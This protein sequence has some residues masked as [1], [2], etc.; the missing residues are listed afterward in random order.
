MSTTQ[1][2]RIAKLKKQVERAESKG[3]FNSVFHTL[4]KRETKKEPVES[5]N[6]RNAAKRRVEVEKDG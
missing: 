3:N 5:V 1:N 6:S 2:K 4:L